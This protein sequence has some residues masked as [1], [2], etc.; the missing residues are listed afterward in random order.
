MALLI[1]PIAQGVLALAA[2][3][4]QA[5][6][7]LVPLALGLVLARRGGGNVGDLE[8]V[9]HRGERVTRRGQEAA[10]EHVH[11]VA[12]DELL[13]LGH[14]QGGLGLVVLGGELHREWAHLVLVLLQPQDEAVDLVLAHL[15]EWARQRR[16]E[17]DADLPG[18]GLGGSR[19]EREAGRCE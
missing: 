17:A 11:L 7:V 15:G 2:R 12:L 18:S 3:E 9:R 8:L 1:G 14:G 19:S 6:V 10:Q 16:D 4:A 5:R 13:G